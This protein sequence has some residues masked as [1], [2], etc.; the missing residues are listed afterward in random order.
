MKQERLLEASG[1]HN[2]VCCLRSDSEELNSVISFIDEATASARRVIQKG[3]KE[4]EYLPP[5]SYILLKLR[6]LHADIPANRLHRD[7]ITE[8]GEHRGASITV[9]WSVH[10]SFKIQF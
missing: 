10:T 1:D 5:I 4:C 7:N 3:A 8:P 6:V 2:N 9:G